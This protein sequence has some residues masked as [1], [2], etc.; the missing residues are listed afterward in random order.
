MTVKRLAVLDGWRGISILL[1]LCGHLL[2]V[3]PKSWAM[4]IA[5]AGAGMAIFFTLSGFLITGVLLNDSNIRRFLIHRV[6]RIVP[7]AWLAMVLTLALTRAEP[8]L[9]LPHL[10]FYA[11]LFPDLLVS[12]TQ[13][14]WSLCVEM[15]FYFMVALL[16]LTLGRRALYAL[17][18]I[19]VAVT[20]YRASMHYPLDIRTDK[21][22]DEILAGCTLALAW[23]NRPTW[24]H[25]EWLRFVPLLLAPLLI[26]SAHGSLPQLNYLRPYIAA[27]LVGSTLGLSAGHGL[28]RL[29]S[30][31]TLRYVAE[32]S[33]ALYVVHG[34]LVASWLDTGDRVVKYMKRPVLL[35]LTWLLAHLSSRHYEAY[36]IG[37]GKRWAGK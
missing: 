17:P 34:C 20:L 16:V 19:A 25:K 5:V 12:G 11:N 9:Y 32:I 31:R 27:A 4:N 7:L 15:Q 35:G 6:M 37:L 13:H 14:F 18:A 3:G 36:F 2:P 8:R 26:A 23:A 24:F 33:F 1:V 30:S 29:L 28:Q 21:R 22:I 10:L